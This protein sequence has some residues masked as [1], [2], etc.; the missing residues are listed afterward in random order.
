MDKREIKRFISLMD[1]AFTLYKKL[2]KSKTFFK[3]EQVTDNESYF[4]VGNLFTIER[5]Y[6]DMVKTKDGNYAYSLKFY[7]NGWTYFIGVRTKSYYYNN[8][9]EENVI[10][11][12]IQRISHKNSKVQNV[13]LDTF[14]KNFENFRIKV[15]CFGKENIFK[16]MNNLVNRHVKNYKDDFL[17]DKETIL[18]YGTGKYYF[19]TRENGTVLIPEYRFNEEENKLIWNHYKENMKVQT[20]LVDVEIIKEN[21]PYGKVTP[22]KAA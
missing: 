1:E 14:E 10:E 18:K 17:L 4:E 6:I 8:L 16:K 9:T 11:F 5:L 21:I 13:K 19:M 3:L 12:K 22:I 2:D 7:N 15:E 20:Y